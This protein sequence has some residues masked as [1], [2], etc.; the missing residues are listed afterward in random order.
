MPT[1]TRKGP[2][3]NSRLVSYLMHHLQMFIASLGFLSRQPFST[4][5]TSAVIAIA[6]AL[7]AGLYIALDNASQ[8]SAG[9][10]GTTQISLFLKDNVN[11]KQVMF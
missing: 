9:W 10:D 5:M 4:L 7:P 11:I 8:L 6:L 1:R 3:Q 2:K